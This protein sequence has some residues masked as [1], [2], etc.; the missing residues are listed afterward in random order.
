MDGFDL[1][2]ASFT[3]EIRNV[4]SLAGGAGANT[5]NIFNTPNAWNFG[6]TNT[7]T[8]GNTLTFSAIKTLNGGIDTDIFA[9][10]A[11]ATFARSSMAAAAAIR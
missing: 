10:A 11:G 4:N 9:F 7:Y 6:A 2:A 3:G 1:T 8:N 5:L